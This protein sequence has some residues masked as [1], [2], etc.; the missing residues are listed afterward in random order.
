MYHTPSAISI[1]LF[2]FS[3]IPA[4]KSPPDARETIDILDF[5]FPDLISELG[6]EA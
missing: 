3:G 4:K 6:S 1:K 2:A 5:Q